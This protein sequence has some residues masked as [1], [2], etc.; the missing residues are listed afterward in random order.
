[1]AG[2]I[3][4]REK[5]EA[6]MLSEALSKSLDNY[7]IG[8]KIRTLRTSK[9]LGLAQLGDH[10]GL[11]AGMLSKIERGQVIPTLPTLMRIA[12]VFGVG[13]DHFFDDGEA[14]VLEVIR[15]KNRLK[16]PDTKERMPSYYFESLDYPVN[17][18]PID[19]YLSEFVP[20]APQ[21]EP[22]E[23]DGIELVYVISGSIEIQI[24]GAV[25][26]LE[27]KDSMYFDARHPHSYK[28][29]SDDRATAII[30]AARERG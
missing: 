8:Q 28:C 5:C 15:S 11:S 24:H 20:R 1:M 30:V 27:P 10:T 2:K 12:L 3:A 18:R 4:P 14:P 6:K 23:H 16:L 21:S 19:A 7:R 17:D 26:K 13:L 9:S 25:H 22:H 29:I